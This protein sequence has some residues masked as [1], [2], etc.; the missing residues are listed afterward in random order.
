MRVISS[1]LSK[2]GYAS[3]AE[4]EDDDAI[5][6]GEILQQPPKTFRGVLDLDFRLLLSLSSGG[7]GNCIP[8][9]GIVTGDFLCRNI[10]S[11]LS[12][13]PSSVSSGSQSVSG[14]KSSG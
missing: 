10:S 1:L 7:M 8:A 4:P 5:D 11:A 9:S 13:S 6:G 12:S 3:P 14:A 2:N